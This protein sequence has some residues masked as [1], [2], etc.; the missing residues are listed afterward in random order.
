LYVSALGVSIYPLVAFEALLRYNLF[1]KHHIKPSC[2]ICVGVLI[3]LSILLDE[4]SFKG[5]FV[6]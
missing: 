3:S 1:S 5:S 6:E 2:T 4:F